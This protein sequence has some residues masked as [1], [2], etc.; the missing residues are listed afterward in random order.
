M[1]VAQQYASTRFAAL[2]SDSPTDYDHRHLEAQRLAAAYKWRFANTSANCMHYSWDEALAEQRA[3]AGHLAKFQANQRKQNRT[4]TAL[5]SPECSIWGSLYNQMHVTWDLKFVRAIFYVNDTLTPQRLPQFERVRGKLTPRN[6]EFAF[7]G[8]VKPGD[9]VRSKLSEGGFNYSAWR[10]ARKQLR[11]HALQAAERA[12]SL[13]VLAQRFIVTNYNVSL[14]VVQYVFT[15]E[16][17]HGG[18]LL[19]RVRLAK[20]PTRIEA[21]VAGRQDTG[22]LTDADIPTLFK[23]PPLGGTY[24]FFAERNLHP[25]NR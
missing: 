21:R 3:Y 9:Y 24:R 8:R 15:A 5:H 12:L 16:C 23:R 2:Y 20:L 17:F 1:T 19:R 6:I 7:N 13:A 4:I 22:K 14:P 10:E 18:P 25:G 11:Q